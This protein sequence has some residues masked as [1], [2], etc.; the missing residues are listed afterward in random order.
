MANR[1][2]PLV[3]SEYQSGKKLLNDLLR[4][5]REGNYVFRGISRKIEWKPA[6]QRYYSNGKYYNLV[7]YEYRMLYDFFQKWNL[8]H[9]N[10]SENILE[11]VA[12]AQHYGIPTRLVD[13]TRD[14]YVALYFAVNNN[15]DPDDGCYSLIY[16][17]LN[18]HTVLDSLRMTL[19]VGDI[20]K[21]D[22]D[23]LYNYMRFLRTIGDREELK[24]LLD[25]RNLDL[26]EMNVESS[27]H[28]NEDGLIFYDSPLSNERLLA[29]KGL[30]S[31]PDSLV[32]QEAANQIKKFTEEIKIRL[33]PKDRDELIKYLENM[34][35]S[36][37]YL[38]P[39][40]QNLCRYIVDKTIKFADE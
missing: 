10:S 2:N 29:Q 17:N 18:N 32:D 40:L 26:A 8:R 28:Y 35:Y 19:T 25:T 33:S 3:D 14:P 20:I 7:E 22:P 37:N 12:S 39:D 21:G 31:I 36:R 16:T 27:L 4:L 30:F 34:N 38:F 5:R 13:W 1:S 23:I 15:S 9:F 11:L 24:G 6:I